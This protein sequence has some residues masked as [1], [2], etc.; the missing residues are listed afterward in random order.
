MPSTATLAMKMVEAFRPRYLCMTGIAAG[1][2]GECSL[3][4]VI[5]ADPCWD[6]GSGKFTKCGEE[7]IF[8]AAP[9]QLSLDPFEKAKIKALSIKSS[10]LETIRSNWSGKRIDSVLRLHL[11]PLASGA[12][13]LAD[14]YHVDLIRQQ[15]RKVIG[16]DMEAYAIFAT[17]EASRLPRPLPIVLK[18][19]V[20]FGEP[21]K[22]DAQQSYAAYASA[23]ILKL[24]MEDESR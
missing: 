17:A 3:G 9:E 12:A 24:L 19:V 22:Q 13:V 6:W 20:D 1:V 8:E 7:I 21:D 4:D 16:I 10:S 23:E 15:Q 2:R 11:G 14:G 18:G 5:A